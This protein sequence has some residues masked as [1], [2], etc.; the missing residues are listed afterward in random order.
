MAL[1]TSAL[2]KFGDSAVSAG[3][4]NN[5]YFYASADADATIIA[6]GYFNNARARLHKGDIII[7]AS[8][9][10]GTPN[11]KTYVVTAVPASGNI[12]VAVSS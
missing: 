12:T 9:I 8:S 2:T 10:G 1:T 3:A 7:T 11:T 4:V 5:I 6:A